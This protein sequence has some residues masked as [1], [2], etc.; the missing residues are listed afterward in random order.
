[1][2][3]NS[4]GR[5]FNALE[6]LMKN[7]LI[8]GVIRTF[9]EIFPEKNLFIMVV[10][11]TIALSA[12]SIVKHWFFLSTAWDLGIFNQAFWSTVHGK[13][14]YYTVEPW[15][16]ENFF[17]THFSPILI[18][19]VPFYAIHPY[20]E[21]LLILHSII[22]ALG[23]IPLYHLAKEVLGPSFAVKLSLAY[24]VN[25]LVVGANLF[26]FHVEAFL[27]VT[28]FS[29]IYFLKKRNF[30]FYALF[31]FISL[32]TLEYAAFL[33]LLIIAYELF[34][35]IGMKSKIKQLIPYSI[36]TFVMSIFW[37]FLAF[38]LR[39]ALRVVETKELSILAPIISMLLSNP[40]EIIYQL[41]LNYPLKIQYVLVLSGGFF[42]SS[43]LS[44]YFLL[45]LPWLLV[46]FTLNYDP[47]YTMGFQ[48]SLVVIPFFAVSSIYGLKRILSFI[49]LDRKKISSL[50]LI[51]T[52][53]LSIWACSLLYSSFPN[54]DIDYAEN[55][56]RVISLIPENASVLTINTLHPHVS[57][58][59]KAWLL[60]ISYNEPYKGF[61][62][63]IST[64]WKEYATNFLRTKNPD[65]ILWDI[66]N[67]GIDAYN[68]NLTISE[69]LSRVH[70]GVYALLDRILLLK[71][72]YYGS[73]ILFEPFAYTFN[74][75]NIINYAPVEVTEESQSVSEKVLA[76]MGSS[77]NATFATSSAFLP[78][79]RYILQ[80]RIKA[81][82]VTNTLSIL[83]IHVLV[84]NES[85][86]TIIVS[87]ADLIDGKWEEFS[88]EFKIDQT[89][90]CAKLLGDKL[91]SNTLLCVDYIKI[92]QQSY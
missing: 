88:F 43:F 38:Y 4:F 31:L 81:S 69:L 2:F 82:N 87:S 53:F 23:A 60:P 49:K 21:S 92:I 65:F 30:K 76:F 17:A 35:N 29:L 83:K 42:F 15:L 28:F 66:K 12:A 47:Y 44:S 6:S 14:F 59:Y 26:D 7:Q 9:E 22:I 64:V 56:N 91:S 70:Y 5:K 34:V 33:T 18:F 8:R 84:G 10:S 37:L 50:V 80:F 32:C 75:K 74:Y 55:A 58:R 52:L 51:S 46:A 68:L 57:S 3:T 85:L 39:S 19:L 86:G 27:P 77:E 20:P 40:Y 11:Y 78:H 25:P 36:L 62:T 1:M 61:E 72:G 13:F 89:L 73:P 67:G 41:T 54:F 16:G 63:G 71:K 45:S 90:V 79:G 24:L 48:Y